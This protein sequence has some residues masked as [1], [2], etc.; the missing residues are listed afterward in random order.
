LKQSYVAKNFAM[1]RF[2]K[3]NDDKIRLNEQ[4]ICYTLLEVIKSVMLVSQGEEFS[5]TA[6]KLF[7]EVKNLELNLEKIV[8]NVKTKQIDK[9]RQSL[10]NQYEKK[11]LTQLAPDQVKAEVSSTT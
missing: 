3:C 8:K 2:Q 5:D 11:E 6:K 10:L 7:K 1:D 4:V 9:K